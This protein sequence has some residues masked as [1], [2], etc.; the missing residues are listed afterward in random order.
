MKIGVDIMILIALFFLL[1]LSF[2]FNIILIKRILLI[3]KKKKSLSSKYGRITEQFFPFI[4]NYPYDPTNFRFIGSPIDG[5]QFNN[6][7]IVFVEF[8]A[9]NSKLSKREK[10]IKELVENKKV[11]FKVFRVD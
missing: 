9:S 3:S 6:D 2:Y 4:E 5:I 11:Y 8:K 10:E 1:F 7:S